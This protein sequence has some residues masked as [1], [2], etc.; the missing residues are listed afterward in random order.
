MCSILVGPICEL[1]LVIPGVA[2][3]ASTVHVHFY[4]THHNPQIKKP[5]MHS[6]RRGTGGR[7]SFSGIVATVF[8]SSGFLGRYVCNRLGKIGTQVREY[9]LF[10]CLPLIFAIGCI[11][12]KQV[13][14]EV[15]MLEFHSIKVLGIFKTS[16]QNR[17]STMKRLWILTLQTNLS[18]AI[19]HDAVQAP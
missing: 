6:L 11:R 16:L 9:L 15:R 18:V 2:A 4:C 3:S 19:V 10:W 14:P 8:G 13:P 17:S 12:I 7:S 5:K 1:F